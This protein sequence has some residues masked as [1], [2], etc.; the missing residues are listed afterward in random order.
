M[1]DEKDGDRHRYIEPWGIVSYWRRTQ[2]ALG[3][4]SQAIAC[5]RCEANMSRVES[6]NH[7]VSF[8]LNDGGQFLMFERVVEV[9]RSAYARGQADRSREIRALL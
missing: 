8:D 4:V 2:P 5:K 3:N 7:V 9:A 1:H 6:L